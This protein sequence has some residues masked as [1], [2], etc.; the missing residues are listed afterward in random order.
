M[1]I[2]HLGNMQGVNLGQNVTVP[3]PNWKTNHTCYK[4]GKEGCLGRE[5]P[6][7]GTLLQYSKSIDFNCHYATDKPFWTYAIFYK[8]YTFR[9]NYS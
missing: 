1:H 2:G 5:C 9:D 3:R 7:T 6:H 4:Y 8:T